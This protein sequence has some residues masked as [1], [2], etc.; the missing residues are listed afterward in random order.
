MDGGEAEDET[1]RREGDRGSV[2]AEEDTRV[3]D[4]CREVAEDGGVDG[5]GGGEDV[6]G[7]GDG[8]AGWVVG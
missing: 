4:E 8:A 5:G 3:V 1:E 6:V 7:V 2:G